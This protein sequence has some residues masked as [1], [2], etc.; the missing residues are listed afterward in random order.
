MN[1]VTPP[2]VIEGLSDD[3]GF[4]RRYRKPSVG[5]VSPWDN[6]T[7]FPAI[8]QKYSSIEVKREKGS[9]PRSGKAQRFA[10]SVSDTLSRGYTKKAQGKSKP[11]RA[12]PNT[13]F[14]MS[15]LGHYEALVNLE[16]VENNKVKYLTAAKKSHLFRSTEDEAGDLVSLG[17]ARV[18]EGAE[19]YE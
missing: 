11:R 15:D 7:A 6:S 9:A 8:R 18:C 19:R 1:N 4:S 2:A 5:N 13:R 3:R 12:V 10:P 16:R 14:D 17:D